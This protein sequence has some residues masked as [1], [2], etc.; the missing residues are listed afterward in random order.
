MATVGGEAATLTWIDVPQKFGMSIHYVKA[1]TVKLG[2]V[3]YSMK[4][5]QEVD[6]YTW[7]CLLPGM[8]EEFTR[9]KK[10]TIEEAKAQ[11]EMIIKKWFEA[12][13]K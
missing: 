7:I 8:K 11:I 1:G 13:A 5:K 9:G 4:S 6:S 10:P 12:T 2:S 3:S